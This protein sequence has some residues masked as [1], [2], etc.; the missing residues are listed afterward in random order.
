MQLPD[1]IRGFVFLFA[2][3]S[4]PVAAVRGVR[5]FREIR[6]AT[7]WSSF[8]ER[9][10]RYEILRCLGM[11]REGIVFEVKP[12]GRD[13]E[14]RALK[15]LDSR[16]GRGLRRRLELKERLESACKVQGL[17]SWPCLPTVYGLDI[18]KAR[19]H[20]V[21]FEEMELVRGETLTEAVERGEL[22]RWTLRERLDAFDEL[23]HGLHA[24]SEESVNFVHI[25]PD[26]VMVTPDRRL[27]LI[28]ISGFR[29]VRLTAAKRRRI[30]R[31][32]ART[33]LLLMKDQQEAV[34]RGRWGG[35]ARELLD[36]LEIYRHL[37]KGKRPPSELELFTIR[38]LQD[39]IRLAFNLKPPRPS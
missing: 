6:R 33:F 4:T 3:I 17:E 7:R 39:R 8:L 31:R 30:F 13:A 2:A 23:L 1:L 32:L 9:F 35:A 34:R 36:Q 11:G 29:L 22:E 5:R 19:G 15:L 28:D 38:Q 16:D 10:S 24:L 25:D 18:I 26:N 21:P 20:A 37:P 14:T 12:D 27:R